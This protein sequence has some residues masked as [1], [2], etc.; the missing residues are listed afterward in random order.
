[1]LLTAFL[2]LIDHVISIPVDWQNLD[3][4]RGGGMTPTWDCFGQPLCDYILLY[5]TS[6]PQAPTLSVVQ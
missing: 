5:I 4:S 2:F 6:T 1:M 3:A